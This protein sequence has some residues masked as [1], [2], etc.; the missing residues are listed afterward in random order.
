MASRLVFGERVRMRQVVSSAGIGSSRVAG[1][2]GPP[3]L[4]LV[5]HPAAP[6]LSV[7]ATTSAGVPYPLSECL[8]VQADTA[9]K[10][11]GD[12]SNAQC[13][14]A[15]WIRPVAQQAADD[16]GGD[17]DDCQRGQETQDGA[18]FVTAQLMPVGPDAPPDAG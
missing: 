6:R 12:D 14:V 10:R 2:R 18:R 16:R 3:D 17:R 15:E 1:H 8:A 11:G 7:F 9:N 4:S 5:S 13:Q